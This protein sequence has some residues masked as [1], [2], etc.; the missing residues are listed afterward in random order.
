MAKRILRP[1]GTFAPYK[2]PK[3]V[4]QEKKAKVEKPKGDITLPGATTADYVLT[5]EESHK[6]LKKLCDDRG[7]EYRTNESKASLLDKLGF[8]GGVEEEDL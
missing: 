2:A 5:G 6:E 3:V 1:D 4:H 8:Q 7:I